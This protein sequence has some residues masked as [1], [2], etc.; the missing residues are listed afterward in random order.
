VAEKVGA[1]REGVLRS[2]VLLPSGPSDAVMY[3]LVR[4]A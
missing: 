4:P 1:T 2:R 3:S